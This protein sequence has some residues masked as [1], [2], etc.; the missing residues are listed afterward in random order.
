MK[1]CHHFSRQ[2]KNKSCAIQVL[3]MYPKVT[4]IL[5]IPK[6]SKNALT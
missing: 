4:N 1:L 3:I 6:I 5:G 2:K